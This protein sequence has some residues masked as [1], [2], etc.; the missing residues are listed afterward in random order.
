MENNRHSKALVFRKTVV[1]RARG[2]VWR[3]RGDWRG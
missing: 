3:G 1:A 2:G